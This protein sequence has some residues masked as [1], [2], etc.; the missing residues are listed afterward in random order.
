MASAGCRRV[1]LQL[2]NLNLEEFLRMIYHLSHSIY[3]SHKW[4]TKASKSSGLCHWTVHC[5]PSSI[6]PYPPDPSTALSG[7]LSDISHLIDPPLFSECAFTFP[8]NWSPTLCSGPLLPA[9][10]RKTLVSLSNRQVSGRA[11]R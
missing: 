1:S 5:L 3:L 8:S 11:Q 9:F 7:S 10:L 4:Q 6:L 2:C